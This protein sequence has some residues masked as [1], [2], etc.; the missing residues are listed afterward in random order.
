MGL[1]SKSFQ[2]RKGEG[3]DAVTQFLEDKIGLDSYLIKDIKAV[4]INP[5]VTEITVLYQDLADEVLESIAPREGG[6]FTSAIL[7]STFDARLL[8]N[9]PVDS[10]TVVTGSFV[11]DGTD[12]GPVDVSIEDNSNSYYVKLRLTGAYQT[13]DFHEFRINP[14]KLLFQGGQSPQFA[15]VGGYVIHD[16]SSAHLGDKLLPFV[17]RRRGRVKAEVLRLGKGDNPQNRINEFLTQRNIEENRLIAY[18]SATRENNLVDAYFIYIKA[19]EPQIVEGFPLNNSLLPDVSAPSNVTLVFS[20]QLDPGVLTSTDGLFTVE[21]GFGLSTDVAASDLELSSDLRT[22]KIDTT[23]YFTEQKVYSIV[24]RPGI[25]G[26]DGTEKIKPEQ[27]N[28]HVNAYEGGVASSFTGFTGVNPTGGLEPAFDDPKLVGIVPGFGFTMPTSQGDPIVIN[29]ADGLTGNDLVGGPITVSYDNTTLGVTGLNTLTLLPSG[30]TELYISSGVVTSEKIQD[31]TIV[32][33]DVTVGHF[34]HGFNVT[35][36]NLVSSHLAF[37]G[38]G[39]VDVILSGQTLFF[40]GTEGAGAGGGEPYV[41]YQATAGLSAE[42]I[43]GEGSGIIIRNIDPDLLIDVSGYLAITGHIA[44]TTIHFTETSISHTN[45]QNVGSIAHAQLDSHYNNATGVHGIG[46]TNSVVG[47]ATDQ[48][49][50]NKHFDLTNTWSGS[51]TALH[52]LGTTG[53]HLPMNIT[54]ASN[55]FV[56]GVGNTAIFSGLV[57]PTITSFTNAQHTHATAAQGGQLG[58]TAFPAGQIVKSL[59]EVAGEGAKLRDDVLVGQAGMGTNNVV[60]W[61]EASNTLTVSGFFDSHFTGHTGDVTLHPTGLNRLT[62]VVLTSPTNNEVLL[63]NGSQWVNS[64]APVEG[65]AVDARPTTGDIVP[66]ASVGGFIGTSANRF[67]GVYAQTGSFGLGTTT[68]SD[69]IRSEG[70]ISGQRYLAYSTGVGGATAVTAVVVPSQGSP[71]LELFTGVSSFASVLSI[72]SSGSITAPAGNASFSGFVSGDITPALHRSFGV[73]LLTGDIIGT[74]ISGRTT[75]DD[76]TIFSYTVPGGTLSD[77]G[78]L[79]VKMKGYIFNNSGGN[80]LFTPRISWGGSLV[81]GDASNLGNSTTERGYELQF[82]IQ[83]MNSTSLQTVHGLAFHDN[84][85]ASGTTA[86]IGNWGQSLQNIPFA[87]GMDES[88][89]VDTTSDAAILVELRFGTA[90]ISGWVRPDISTVEHWEL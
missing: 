23:S 71:A 58:S 37:T 51:V 59:G 9:H 36:S 72:N 85:P 35:G 13:A 45:I 84:S 34:V 25:V 41:T 3:L 73:H 62:D 63:Y 19:L 42:R 18:T 79:E 88:P 77:R 65:G 89:T 81:W 6:I 28:L 70:F 15:P 30:V 66:D 67:S 21:R 56:T 55:V 10:A 4:S 53:L 2:I 75:D 83:N 49:L 52:P 69:N 64:S 40:T 43:I 17:N 27:W 57:D 50:S 11:V 8:F 29:Y 61:D 68:I 22:V 90:H 87:A 54:G 26:L 86:G 32:S 47:T 60:E 76:V 5:T 82:R 80:L 46:I 24:A 48:V 78:A 7:S 1:K 14:S 12:L 74:G 38:A 33:G 31:G 44:D 20:S 16:Q 39:T